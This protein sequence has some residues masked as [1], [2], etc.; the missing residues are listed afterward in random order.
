MKWSIYDPSTGLFT[1]QKFGGSQRDVV[2]NTPEGMVALEGDYDHIGQMVVDGEVVARDAP[3]DHYFEASVARFVPIARRE[4][5]LQDAEARR[6]IAEV[7]TSALRAQRELIRNPDDAE[8]KKRV[9]AAD[10]EIAELRGHLGQPF[11]I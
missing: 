10:D 6:R 5:A 9:L 11:D 1:G 7:E 8:A 2:G 4:M 3:P